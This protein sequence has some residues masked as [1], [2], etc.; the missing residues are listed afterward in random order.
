MENVKCYVDSLRCEIG[1]FLPTENQDVIWQ[2]IERK[3]EQLLTDSQTTNVTVEKVVEK[4]KE[5]TTQPTSI[6]NMD[7]F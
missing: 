4:V 5:E 7:M 3:M 1:H 6:L 2:R